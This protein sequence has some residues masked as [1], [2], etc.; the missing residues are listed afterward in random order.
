M[1]KEIYVIRHGETAYNK[2]GRVQGR[3][4]DSDLNAT[5]REQASAFY[6]LYKEVPFQKVYTSA[7]KRTQQ[8]VQ[9][10]ID[11]G[12]PWESH[13]EIDELAWGELEGQL[14][15]EQTIGAFK[16]IT[17]KWQAGDYEARFSGGESPNEVAERLWKFIELIKDRTEEKLILVCMHGRALRL[18]MCLLSQRP[19]S[20]MY[21][22]PHLN[23]GLYK[24]SFNGTAFTL[25][26]TNNTDHLKR[27]TL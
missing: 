25:T 12:I 19:I 18:L 15:N 7:L 3:G 14:T 23:T 27:L 8:T 11:D 4:I 26:E 6:A 13:A 21:D 1:D 5:G 24:V 10:F 20:A 17:E 16:D 9:G 2:A 22:F